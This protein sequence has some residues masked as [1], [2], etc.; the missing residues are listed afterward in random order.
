MKKDETYI[1][2]TVNYIK[3]NLQK[4]Y[5]KDSLKWALINQGNSRIEVDKAFVQAEKEMAR[6]SS[7]ESQRLASMQPA[8][9]IEPIMPEVEKK[10]GFFSRFFGS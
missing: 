5:D 10:K 7:I 2:S 8:P 6:D 3:R 1:T 9:R 4:G